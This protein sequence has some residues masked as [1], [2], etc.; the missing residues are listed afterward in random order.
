M[1]KKTIPFIPFYFIRHGQTDWNLKERWQ[2]W[3]DIPLNETGHAQ[4]RSAVSV[5]AGKG[6]SHIVS[7][8]L[9]R[10]HKTAEII[11]EHLRVPLRIV[12]GLKEC[13]LG[14]L[15]GTVKD[16][17]IISTDLNHAIQMGKGE[18]VDEFKARIASALHNVLDPKY[19]TLIVAHGGVYWAIME[20]IGFKEQHSHNCIPYL[21]VPPTE[22]QTS[23]TVYPLDQ[24]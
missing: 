6:I 15:E 24:V 14:A 4:A 8:P 3:A 2:G 12:D 11:N 7:S 9:I 10:A 22:K 23:W 13:S 18:H 20:M 1:I 17:F 5:L 19:I 21:F 16:R